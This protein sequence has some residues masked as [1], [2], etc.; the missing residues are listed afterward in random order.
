MSTVRRRYSQKT[1]K[2]LFALSGNQC[3]YPECANSLIE[4]STEQSDVHVS[5]QI[6]HVYAVSEDGPRGKS[7]LTE[8]ELNSPDNLVLMCSHHHGIVDGQYESYPADKLQEWKQAHETKMQ[9]RLSNDLS[10]VSSDLFSSPYFPT[11]LIDQKIEEEI[12]YLRKTRFFV[13]M[14]STNKAMLL[15]NQVSGGDLSGGTAV[16]RSRAL[17]WCARLLALSEAEDEA[18]LF[19]ELAESLGSCNEIEIAKAF[20]LSKNGDR[21][22]ALTL[23]AAIPSPA[24]Y[25]AALMI[26]ANLEGAASAISWLQ[27]AGVEPNALD[28][29]GKFFLLNQKIELGAWEAA[30]EISNALTDQELIESPALRHTSA[31]VC[32]LSA[33]PTEFRSFVSKQ[34]PMNTADFQLAS[35]AAAMN[36]RKRAQRRFSE[37]ASVALKLDCRKAATFNEKYALWLELLNPE[38]TKDGLLRLEDKFRDLETALQFV[39]LGLDFKIELDFAAVDQMIEQSIALHGGIKFEAAMARLALATKQ[40]SAKGAS[41]YI[42]RHFDDL[43]EFFDQN[44]LGAVQIEALSRAGMLEKAKERLLVLL[45]GGLPKENEAHLRMIIAEADG[46]DPVNLRKEQFRKTDTLEDLI[47]L[48]DLLEDQQNWEEM[49]DFG[50]KLLQRTNSVRAAELLAAAWINFNQNDRLVEFLN[51]QP[52]LRKQSRKLNMFY[53]WA[54]YNEGLLLEAKSELAKFDD[55][56]DDVNYRALTVNLGITSGDWL[57]LSVYVAAEYQARDKRT[58]KDL[59]QTAQLAHHLGAPTARDLTL[60]AA[61]KGSDDPQVLASAYFLSTTAGWEGDVKVTQWIQKAVELSDNQGPIQSMTL[62]DLVDQKPAWDRRERETWQMLG[63]GE[64]PLYLAA[65]LLNKTLIDLTLFPAFTNLSET[66]PRRRGIIPAYSGR[67]SPTP[68]STNGA[69]VG[70]DVTTL[71]TLSFLNI[72]EKAIDA[73]DTVYV[74]HSTLNWLFEEK[75][76]ASFHQPS[77]I[78]KA[79]QVRNMLATEDLKKLSPS[80]APDSDLCAEAGEDFAMLIAEAEKVG[81]DNAVQHIVVCPAPIHRIGSLLEEDVDLADHSNVICSCRSVVEKLRQKGQVTADEE[82]IAFAYL[83]INE[84][85]WPLQQPISDG[86]VLY[87]TDLAV[88]YFLQ[89]GILDKLNAGG[90]TAV[91]SPNSV[92]EINSLISYES[93]ADKVNEKIEDIRDTLNSR[94]KTGKIKVGKQDNFDDAE[95][96]TIANHPTVGTLKLAGICNSIIIDDRMVNQHANLEEGKAKATV[97][98]TLDLLDGM[99]EAGVISLDENFKCRTQLRQ[100]GYFIIPVHHDEL[101][102]H[103]NEC[104]VT[105]DK[106]N[107]TAELKAIRQNLLRIRMGDWLQLP[108]ENPWLSATISVFIDVL[109]DMWKS[110]VE[111]VKARALSNWILDQIDIRGWIHF[112]GAS[113]S[114]HDVNFQRTQQIIMLLA[115]LSGVAPE[116]SVAYW[117]WLGERVLIQLKEESP[118]LYNSIVEKMRNSVSELVKRASNG[119]DVT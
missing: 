18:K 98:T 119:G 30:E 102:K 13:E 6:C 62:K 115:P 36:A 65:K 93:I 69:I 94:I 81:D 88:Q 26:V 34:L 100:G 118:N 50:A 48:V 90:F 8:K 31:M 105:N 10:S 46:A 109:R 117:E 114:E 16:V 41:I 82:K 7:M 73:F 103:L 44:S 15:G 89:L 107:E 21:S 17:A 68:L 110:N 78:K 97:F 74:P 85:E 111:Q 1:I 55:E 37:V 22:D 84:K 108:K 11:A 96:P 29:D 4:P 113:T 9:E 66:D 35:D 51:G 104:Q 61:A 40:K 67:R 77:R 28:P 101:T 60:A 39:P 99:V 95:K 70:M 106:L 19:L 64:V 79:H 86:A 71:L 3:A 43:S 20:L 116:I 42:E 14:E 80:A 112:L 92:S 53:C 5:A 57:S 87:L 59:M 52:E 56:F 47:V 38:T 91:V 32:L 45:E 24:A 2:V 54:L 83:K 49:L 63:R 23:L 12:E 75:Q 33:V 25:S 72:L 58:A 76:R 27:D